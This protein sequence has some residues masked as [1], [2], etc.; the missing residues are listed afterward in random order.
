[1]HTAAIPLLPDPGAVR[2]GKVL[3][4]A[5]HRAGGS[6]CGYQFVATEGCF[7]VALAAGDLRVV[8][9]ADDGRYLRLQSPHSAHELGHRLNRGAERAFRMNERGKPFSAASIN[10]MLRQLDPPVLLRSGIVVRRLPT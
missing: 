2:R 4:Q 10:S 7:P 3:K 1:M 6:V 8:A 9:A 5:R